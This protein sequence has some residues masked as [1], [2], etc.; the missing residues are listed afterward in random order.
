MIKIELEFH[1]RSQVLQSIKN[2]STVQEGLTDLAISNG[3][4]D[5]LLFAQRELTGIIGIMIDQLEDH[6]ENEDRNVRKE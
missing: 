4:T 2:L 3:S 1:N 5:K 6:G